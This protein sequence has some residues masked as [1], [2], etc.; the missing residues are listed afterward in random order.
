M[1]I[2]NKDYE[3]VLDY[4]I[5]LIR[6]IYYNIV[7]IPLSTENINDIV[8]RQVKEA[9]TIASMLGKDLYETFN[10]YELELYHMGDSLFLGSLKVDYDMGIIN[11]ERSSD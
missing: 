10:K 7:K 2:S 6:D 9:I 4:K 1:E 11:N 8:S 5:K 3:D